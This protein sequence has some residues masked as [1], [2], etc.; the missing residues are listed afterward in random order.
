MRRLVVA[1]VVTATLSTGLAGV[2]QATTFTATTPVRVSGSSPFAPGCGGPGEAVNG[3][4][5]YL[6]AEVEPW[7]SVNPVNPANMVGFWQQDRWS[8]GGAHGLV[9]GVSMDGGATWRQTW[10]AVSRCAGAAPGD[11]GY[12]ERSTDPW[13]SFSP[14]GDLHAI[15]LSF[16]DSTARNAILVSKSTDG[17]A[18][19]QRPITVRFDNPRVVGNNFNDKESLTADPG[20]SRFAYAVWDRLVSPS[21]RA[22]ASGYEHGGLQAWRGPTWFARTTDGGQTWEPARPIYDPGERNQTISNQIVVTPDGTLV[23]GFQLIKASQNNHGTRGLHIAAMRSTDKGAT[24]SAPVIVAPDP[25]FGTRDPE[26]VVCRS[27]NPNPCNFV[28]TGDLVPD[29]AVDRTG[30]PN[31]GTVYAVWQQHRAF[32]VLGQPVDDA[33][34]LSR[35][36]DGGRT[37]SE[38]V[39]VNQTPAGSYNRQAFI[40][41]VHVRAN[42]D[43]AVSYYDMRNDVAGDAE[44]STDVWIAHSHDAGLSWDTETHLSGPFDMRTAP[45]AGGYF[46]GDYEG[47][48]SVGDVFRPFFVQANTGVPANPTDAF[49]TSAG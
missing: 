39:Q 45:Y 19:W 16:D 2:A 27:F 38:P 7:V 43:V 34:M 5:N 3:G 44:L 11:P 14:N 31:N 47:L 17:G 15:S 10:P 33:I 32:T 28:R 9:A 8:D 30:G 48:D 13:V 25:A 4:F 1:T 40:P 37:W 35:S 18:S 24:W 41:S 22:S 12:F 42:G 49:S 26:P 46:V 20:D 36:T 23:N 21:E 29:F 6:N